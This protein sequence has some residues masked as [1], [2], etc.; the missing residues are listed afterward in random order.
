MSLV[1]VSDEKE[2]NGSVERLCCLVSVIYVVIR[3]FSFSFFKFRILT[4]DLLVLSRGEASAR[5]HVEKSD[6][7]CVDGRSNMP[8]SR[9]IKKKKRAAQS[10]RTHIYSSVL[11][12]LETSTEG[13]HFLNFFF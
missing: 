3:V 4:S 2:T 1:S 9:L 8:V 10:T 7:P 11:L 6:R 5:Y 13:P 12:L